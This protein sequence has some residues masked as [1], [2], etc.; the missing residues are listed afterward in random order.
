MIIGI[1]QKF[2]DQVDERAGIVRAFLAIPR[3]RIRST[4]N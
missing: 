4:N 3:Q 1:D 2:G